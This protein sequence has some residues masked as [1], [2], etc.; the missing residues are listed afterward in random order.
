MVTSRLLK[1]AAM[2]ESAAVTVTV[3][4]LNFEHVCAF[5]SRK[6]DTDIRAP[7]MRADL[8]QARYGLIRVKSWGLT[9]VEYVWTNISADE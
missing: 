3:L 8:K 1:T 7:K 9:I 5:S 2:S 4:R 6:S